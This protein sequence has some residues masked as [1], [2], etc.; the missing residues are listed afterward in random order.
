MSERPVLLVKVGGNDLDNDGFIPALAQALASQADEYNCLVVHGGGHTVSELMQRLDITPKFIDGFRITDEK[1][2]AVTELVLSGQV[3]KL[4]VRALQD[5]GLDALGLSGV[6]GGLLQVEAWSPEMPLVGRVVKVRRGL[7]ESLWQ[8][9]ITPVVSPISRG[10]AGAYNVNA[11]HAAG[12]LAGALQ[13]ERAVF[14]TN[15]PGV[16]RMDEVLSQLTRQQVQQLIQEGHINGG[17]IPKVNAALD[18]LACGAQ[19]AT[20]C[21]LPGFSR[22]SGTIIVNERLVNV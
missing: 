8:M 14:I 15:V 12:A 10:P 22:G 1:T 6:D 2:L 13:A 17:M 21:D 4:L 18:A 11:D 20:I 19:T 7:L 5:A 3:N 9:G 16:K